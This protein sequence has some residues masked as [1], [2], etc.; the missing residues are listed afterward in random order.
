MK[1]LPILVVV[2]AIL[3]SNVSVQAQLSDEERRAPMEERRGK[4]GKSGKGRGEDNAP[5]VGTQA[6]DLGV[7]KL[8]DGEDFNLSNPNRISVLIFGSHT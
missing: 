5:K 4:G 7:K 1:P 8:L 6:P 3:C 2:A